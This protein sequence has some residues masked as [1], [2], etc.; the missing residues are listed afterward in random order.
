M[1]NLF[2]RAAVLLACLPTFAF[3]GPEDTYPDKAVRIV[4]PFAAGG[5]T[6]V[7]ARILAEKLQEQFKQP[8]VVDNRAGASGNIGAELVAKSPADG[9]TLLMGATGILSI[10]DHLYGKLNYNAAKDFVPVSYATQN[11]NILV[12]SPGMP[13]TNVADL[14]QLAKTR[15]GALSFA[16]S[17]P[18]SSTHLS[19]ELF[20]SMT[21]V[22]MLH[23]PYKGS[24]QALTDLLG[25][26]VTM[27]FDNAPSSIG[28]VQQGKL[29]ALAV[30]SRKRLPGLPNVPTLD[31]AGVKG[32][33]SLSWSGVVAPAAT[34]R[35]I[36]LKLNRAIDAILKS[37]DVKAKL[38]NLGVEP[39]GGSPEDFA[40]LIQAEHDKWGKV[41]KTAQIKLN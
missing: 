32:Y 33:E 25:G 24:S 35:A 39:V 17:G 10:N 30:T 22:N 5:S 36:V 14:V 41:I 9:Y 23:V 2:G 21:G 18:G 20:K 8:F 3:A 29:K 16:S 11:A 31:E 38:L 15:P 1:K 4:V 7:V 12:V 40:R 37:D 13:A 27:L 34:P 19:G 26:N 6:D 28:F